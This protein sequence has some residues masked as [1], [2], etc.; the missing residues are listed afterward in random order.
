[1]TER[2]ALERYLEAEEF[3][4]KATA[5]FAQA[6]AEMIEAMGSEVVAPIGN[7]RVR[8]VRSQHVN[9]SESKLAELLGKRE[10]NKYTK[11]V[12]DV[13]ALTQAI[14][15]NKL[16]G[17]EADVLRLFEVKDRAPYIRLALLDEDEA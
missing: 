8:V 9:L 2:M 16:D 17:K 15:D 6:K 4:A 12:L 13:E 14:K 10:F 11:R 1:M 7:Y 3:L 5:N